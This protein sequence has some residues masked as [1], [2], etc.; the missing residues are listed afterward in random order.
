MAYQM[1]RFFSSPGCGFIV[2]G[3]YV[4]AGME[5][6][7]HDIHTYIRWKREILFH[8]AHTYSVLYLFWESGKGVFAWMEQ[9][10][11]PGAVSI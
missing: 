10:N 1:L 11:C 9:K 5:E 4:A 8:K 2:I 3:Y 7:M 6:H